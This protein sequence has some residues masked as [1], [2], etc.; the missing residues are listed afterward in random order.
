MLAANAGE[1]MEALIMGL[2]RQRLANVAPEDLEALWG[3]VEKADSLK[4][5]LRSID[6]AMSV[7][8]FFQKLDGVRVQKAC[9]FVG[10]TCRLSQ[11]IKLRLMKKKLTS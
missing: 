10:V 11:T 6:C 8:T 7:S 4:W 9:T 5:K 2:V 3:P 1:T